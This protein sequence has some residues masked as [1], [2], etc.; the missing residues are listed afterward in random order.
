M[1]AQAVEAQLAE[2]TQELQRL[3]IQKHELGKLLHE[4]QLGSVS[5]IGQVN[6]MTLS[7]CQ[8]ELEPNM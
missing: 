2:T 5:M 7:A 6:H 1:K 4:A 8:D 3:R